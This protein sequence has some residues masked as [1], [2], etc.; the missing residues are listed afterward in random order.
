VTH[1]FLYDGIRFNMK[2]NA[3]PYFIEGGVYQTY[4][5]AKQGWNNQGD[6]IDLSGKSKPCVW[7]QAIS[8]CK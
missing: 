5:A 1:P 3:D 8:N 7:D 4:D 6:P 2:G